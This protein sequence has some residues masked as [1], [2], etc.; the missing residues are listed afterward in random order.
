MTIYKPTKSRYY[1]YDFQFKGERY[2]GSTLCTT[3]ADARAYEAERRRTIAL[4]LKT[5]PKITIDLGF[6]L[7]WDMVGQFEGSAKTS[8]GQLAH[9][10][11]LLG[12]STM[13]HQIGFMEI[14][15]DYMARRRGEKAKNRKTLISNASVNRELELA[16]RIWKYIR[17]S[18]YDA[19]YEGWADHFLSEPQERVRELK[20]QEEADLF[21][22]LPAD[23]AAV[24]EFAMLSGQRRTAVIT[25]LWNRVDLVEGRATVRTKGTGKKTHV[26]HTFPLT[27][28]LIEIVRSRPKVGPF[29]FTYECQR[30][31]PA[32]NDRPPRR[33]GE[34]YPFSAQGWMRQWKKALDDAGIDDFR[35]HDLRHTAGTRI[36]RATG[37]LKV[38][39]K[40]LN[41]TNISTTARYAHVNE[42]DIRA[43]MLMTAD[44]RKPAEP[45]K[46]TFPV[47]KG[48]RDK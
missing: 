17:K 29:V 11:R 16:R 10:Q 47:V 5:L 41:H 14:E 13:M 28:R 20:T 38:V 43:A 18:G 39:Q 37:N 1:H 44:T 15:R 9:L 46:R 21:A 32:R 3:K 8:E 7:W 45:A 12:K 40:L 31:A 36:Q 35:F 48:G 34:R 25:L 23:L 4:G 33:K 26:D 22:H 6:G 27:P 2:Y 19:P 30:P 42:D 24:V